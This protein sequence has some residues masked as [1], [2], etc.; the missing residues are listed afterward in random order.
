MKRWLLLVLCLTAI[1]TWFGCNKQKPLKLD[2]TEDL[3]KGEYKA[4]GLP[5]DN[6]VGTPDVATKHTDHVDG[7]KECSCGKKDCDCNKKEVKDDKKDC[8][9]PHK[10]KPKEKEP[11]KTKE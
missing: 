1:A 5:G 8:D 2:Y 3:K 9:C 7:A 6:Y 4:V 10:D 11:A